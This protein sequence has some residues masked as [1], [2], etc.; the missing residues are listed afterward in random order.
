MEQKGK[1]NH[2][3]LPPR[4]RQ[5]GQTPCPVPRLSSQPLHPCK[6]SP[7]PSASP[8]TALGH[9]HHSTLQQ[10]LVARS[11]PCGVGSVLPSSVRGSLPDERG[12][13]VGILRLQH[14]IIVILNTESV[15]HTLSSLTAALRGKYYSPHF[16]DGGTEAGKQSC[17]DQREP[18]FELQASSLLAPCPDRA[19]LCIHLLFQSPSSLSPPRPHLC[20]YVKGER[21]LQATL[22]AEDGGL[23]SGSH[24]TPTCY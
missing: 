6:T 4:W 22:S 21:S 8:P 16:A 7:L 14:K 24:E 2:D 9:Q 1:S 17:Q 20:T 12:R 11:R 10:E 5:E 18:G 3:E 23:V 19:C 13:S 15:T